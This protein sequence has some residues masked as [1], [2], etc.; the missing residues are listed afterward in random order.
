MKKMIGYSEFTILYKV[1]GKSKDG[2][3]FSATTIGP[4]FIFSL[5]LRFKI[6]PRMRVFMFTNFD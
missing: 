5:V 4:L 3:L 6:R 2:L 1:H